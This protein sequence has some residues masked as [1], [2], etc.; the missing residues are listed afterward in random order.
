MM[1][2]VLG[3]YFVTQSGHGYEIRDSEGAVIAWTVIPACADR[4]V[5]AL[6]LFDQDQPTLAAARVGLPVEPE[7]PGPNTDQ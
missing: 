7:R 3:P 6:T 2:K 5:A 4:I 1:N